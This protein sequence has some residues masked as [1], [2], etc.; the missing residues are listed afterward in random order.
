MT[1][2]HAFSRQRLATILTAD[3]GLRSGHRLYVAFSGGLDSTALLL[4]L[5]QIDALDIDRV[6]ALHVNHRLH[7]DS[8]LWQAECK[9]RC[10]AWGVRYSTCQL[11]LPTSSKLGVEAAARKAR[12]TWFSKQLPDDG[13]LLT[14]H[15]LGDQVETVLANLFRGAGVHGLK[16]IT[17]KRSLGRG[18][19]WRPL[20][21]IE[22]RAL[23]GFVAAQHVSWIK[24]PANE[25]HRYTRNVIRH[26]ILPLI[27]KTWPGAGRTIARSVD[28]WRDAADLLDELAESD[29]EQCAHCK[30]SS[31]FLL[32]AS[33]L[34]G[35]SALRYRNV[36]QFWFK[37]CGFEPP[38][39]KHLGL[40]CK[41]ML[42][43]RP[44]AT[45][46]LGWPGVEVRSYRDWLYLSRPLLKQ[47]L[48]H[49][50]WDKAVSMPEVVING[51]RLS[52]VVVTSGG[53]SKEIYDN[54]AVSIRGRVGGERCWLPGHTKHHKLKKLYQQQGIPPWERDQIP[55][56]YI[57]EELAGVV[58][59]WYCKPFAAKEGELGIE[60]RLTDQGDGA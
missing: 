14:A 10:A 42:N 59:H 17:K 16:G 55:L 12:Y 25:D 27:E 58:G 34:R 51:R 39:R 30:R 54:H 52:A 47:S 5:I 11:E 2:T 26:S 46:V 43:G 37:W 21:N 28:N 31:F 8:D 15:H 1:D 18:Q 24:D 44:K 23:Y 29:L 33:D 49:I 19:V 32:S 60:F 38:S 48:P 36:L 57:D 9:R 20:L 22:R 35:L 13:I 3:F 40:L 56:V 7:K 45:A 41:S 4:A 6:T 53:I 50:D